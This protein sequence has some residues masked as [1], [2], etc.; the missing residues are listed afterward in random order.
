MAQRSNARTLIERRTTNNQLLRVDGDDKQ[1]KL[2]VL[3]GAGDHYRAIA[4]LSY[5]DAADIAAELIRFLHGPDARI[6]VDGE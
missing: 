3:N 5:G 4:K 6:A 2:S 1:V